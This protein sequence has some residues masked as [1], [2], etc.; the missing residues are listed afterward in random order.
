MELSLTTNRT[1]PY[2]SGGKQN[3]I[4]NEQDQLEKVNPSGQYSPNT[5]ED[6][7]KDN[8][9]I[10]SDKTNQSEKKRDGKNKRGQSRTNSETSGN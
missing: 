3:Q 4:V 7:Q 10:N 9:A 1:Q 5:V 8:E 6:N 2:D